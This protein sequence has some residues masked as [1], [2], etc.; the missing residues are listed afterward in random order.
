VEGTPLSQ[1]IPG[2]YT[3]FAD[4]KVKYTYSNG[5]ELNIATTPDDTIYGAHKK[6]E[7]DGGQPNGIRFEGSGGWIWVN[8]DGISASNQDILLTPIPEDGIHLYNSKN[9]MGNFFDCV[10]SRQLPI[11]DVETGHR[12]ATM[13]HLGAIALRTGLKLRWDAGEEQFVGPG[14]DVANTYVARPMRA[15]YDYSMVS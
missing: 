15:P 8:R 11:A 6:K 3:T 12:S 2:G 7:Q 1:P 4:Y 10:R 14:A 13:C 5:V 9:H